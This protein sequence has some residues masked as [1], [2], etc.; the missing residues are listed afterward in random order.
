MA[1]KIKLNINEVAVKDGNTSLSFVISEPSEEA[2]SVE[3]AISDHP[4]TFSQSLLFLPGETTKK[5]SLP[6]TPEVPLTTTINVD[7]SD[8][9]E[10]TLAEFRIEY[11]QERDTA[12]L[13]IDD[14][15]IEGISTIERSAEELIPTTSFETISDAIDQVDETVLLAVSNTTKTTTTTSTTDDTTTTDTTAPSLSSASP[16]D[17]ATAVAVGGNIVLNFSEAVDVESGNIVIYKSSDD[18]TV[19]TIAVTSSQVTGTGT[20]QITINPSSDFDSSTEYYVQIA[21]TGFDD[22]SGNS[23]A[24]ITDKTSLSFTS[25]ADS[26]APTVT[27]FTSTTADGSYGTATFVDSFSLTEEYPYGLAF[28]NDGSKMFVAGFGD[29]DVKEYT[30]STVFDV[31][32]ASL[33][34]SFD[35]SSQENGLRGLAFNNDGTK[36]FILGAAGDDVNEYTLST[37]FDVSTSSFVD[38]FSI[39]GQEESPVGLT[40]NDDGT[41]MFITGHLGQDVNEYTLSTGFDVSTASF[42]D[43]FSV[44][45]Q[46]TSPRG[47]NFNND[48]T[49]MFI[50]GEEDDEVNE[51]TLST[52]F[53]VSTASFVGSLDISSQGWRPHAISFNNDETK[54]FIVDAGSDVVN[55]Y[56]IPTINI[57]ATTSESVQ[58]GDTITVTLDTGD[59][60]VLTAASAGTTL[61]GTYSVGVGDNSSDL[62]VSSFAIG[63]VTDSAGNAMTST[64]LPSSNNIA[65][66][67]AIVIDT[68]ASAATLALSISGFSGAT[69]V[70][71]PSGASGLNAIVSTA[72]AN[73][74]TQGTSSAD[75]IEVRDSASSNAGSIS[76]GSGNDIVYIKGWG[77]ATNTSVTG[78]GGTDTLV[79]NSAIYSSTSGGNK[80]YFNGTGGSGNITYNNF[81]SVVVSDSTDFERKFSATATLADTDGSESLG[82]ITISSLPDSTSVTDS[83]GDAV[84]VSSNAFTIGSVVSGEAQIFTLTNTGPFNFTA[85]GSVTVTESNGSATTTTTASVLIDGVVRGIEYVTSSGMS[86]LTNQEGLFNYQDGDDITF[87]V[88]GVV[89]GTATA[90]DVISGRTFLQDIADVERSNLS[91]GYL[92]N[93]AIFLQSLDANYNPGDGITITQQM[94]TN[95]ADIELD[96]RQASSSEVKQ[97]IEQVGGVYVERAEAMEHVKDMLI[98]YSDMKESDFEL[99]DTESLMARTES[100]RSDQQNSLSSLENDRISLEV[101]AELEDSRNTDQLF[102]DSSPAQSNSQ[103][104]GSEQVGDNEVAFADSPSVINVLDSVLGTIENNLV[105]DF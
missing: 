4:N 95:L 81:S 67:S 45:S 64:T 86:G 8:L 56:S 23:Y 98:E 87:K 94:R 79:I 99:I 96:L 75:Y 9:V 55:E 77:G 58:S 52:G 40:F 68:T 20:T 7:N 31:S 101:L 15:V 42:V 57:T 84:T 82:D 17:D 19:E 80:I 85:N 38:S 3:V 24:G 29:D 32:T 54:M 18:S 11:N 49:K 14:E 66:T 36:M 2:F 37:G 91:D 102:S 105:Y 33:V 60:V 62:T 61:T 76:G 13:F 30:L 72:P 28:N 27:N 47:I 26:T 44:S 104:Y 12:E 71:V 70:S 89:L 93:M 74:T 5:V 6:I 103:D 88:G 90:E 22:S 65:D 92:E 48:G 1:E 46:M 63:S 50:T 43:S 10:L 16:A 59:T 83:D 25:T 41:K 34:D 97:V 53:D 51:Y 73:T 35:V 69:S 39:S 21:A 100:S 78:D